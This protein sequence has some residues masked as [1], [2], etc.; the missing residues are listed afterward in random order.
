MGFATPAYRWS[1]VP[2]LT[3]AGFVSGVYTSAV[4][5]IMSYGAAN[6]YPFTFFGSLSLGL[7]LCAVLWAFGFVPSRRAGATLVAAPIAVHLIDAFPIGSRVVA[8]L[9]I[10]VTLPVVGRVLLWEL[11]EH[12]LV[13]L[14]LYSAFLLVL[15]P[16]RRKRWTLLVAAVCAVM[17]VVVVFSIVQVANSLV[18]NSGILSFPAQ[19]TQACF[20]AAALALAGTETRTP[21]KRFALV[22]VQLGYFLA[23]YAGTYRFVQL[24]RQAEVAIAQEE[25]RTRV[26]SAPSRVDLPALN[27]DRVDRVFL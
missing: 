21:Q 26:A 2:I 19:T 8:P 22:Y 1:L 15:A 12:F 20:L 5:N 18:V 11:V 16:R 25:I 23:V 4:I 24:P 10:D 13:A 17:T 27:E 9:I 7:A 6:P 14:A 3:C